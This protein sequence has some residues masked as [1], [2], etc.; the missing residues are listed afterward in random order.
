MAAVDDLR[1]VWRQ[2]IC[3]QL[4]DVDRS[5][6]CASSIY[7]GSLIQTHTCQHIRSNPKQN[8]VN[9]EVP[10]C[11]A[12]YS[13]QTLIKLDDLDILPIDL[14]NPASTKTFF[15]SLHI[16]HNSATFD[17]FDSFCISWRILVKPIF[18]SHEKPL[19]VWFKYPW[20]LLLRT[21]TGH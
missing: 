20:P 2:D 18:S 1:H 4:E 9:I 12:P 14:V 7:W 19:P 16:P 3:N 6:Q 17:T 11:L 13:S 5:L 21:L 15:I 8:L 10:D